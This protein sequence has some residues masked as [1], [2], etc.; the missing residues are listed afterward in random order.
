[1]KTGAGD[2]GKAARIEK[3][4][5]SKPLL[6]DGD[7]YKEKYELTANSAEDYLQK[8]LQGKELVNIDTKKS[9]KFG[10]EGRKKV[11]SH[12]RTNNLHLKLLAHI[13]TLLEHAIYIDSK[14]A[15]KEKSR[16]DRYDYFVIGISIDGNE[17]S[18]KIT[19]GQNANGEWVYDQHVT[20]AKIKDLTVDR[21]GIPAGKSS[22][23]ESLVEADRITNP[24]QR[25]AFLSNIKDTTLLEILQANSAK[26]VDE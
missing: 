22:T 10:K 24:M 17:C 5:N 9:F 11:T 4:R 18:V 2:G 19:I 8:T 12:S 21:I 6:L 14:P 15:Y 3:L 16:Y 23:A 7:A 1:V 20:E 26:I 13:P 25:Q